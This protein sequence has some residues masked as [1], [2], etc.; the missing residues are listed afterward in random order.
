VGTQVPSFCIGRAV[1]RWIIRTRYG[2][3]PGEKAARALHVEAPGGSTVTH[4]SL[5]EWC[6]PKSTNQQ[7]L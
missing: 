2:P 5:S 1:A 3:Q 4:G 6:G 7:A